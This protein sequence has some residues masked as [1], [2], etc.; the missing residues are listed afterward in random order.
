MFHRLDQKEKREPRHSAASP[1]VTINVITDH[2][3]WLLGDFTEVE[4]IRTTSLSF[5]PPGSRAAVPKLPMEHI[6][7]VSVITRYLADEDTEN[8]GG[9]LKAETSKWW[10][11]LRKMTSPWI[12]GSVVTATI[13]VALCTKRPEHGGLLSELQCSCRAPPAWL[14]EADH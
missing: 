13:V 14:P 5:F 9:S 6:S 2:Y 7:D 8:A 4:L 3:R 11:I 10:H 1:N 12:W